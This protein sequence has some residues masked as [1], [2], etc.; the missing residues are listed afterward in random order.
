MNRHQRR[1]DLRCFR[2]QVHC[3]PIVTHLI[4]A[5]ADLNGFPMLAKIAEAW[6]ASI[7]QRKPWC[8][9]CEASFAEAATSGAFLF[10]EPPGAT[11]IAS[12]SVLC[13]T[14]W[15]DLPDDEIEATC[16]RVLS[17]LVPG[18]KFEARR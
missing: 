3:G 17:A 4:D 14:C 2:H 13:A 15:R 16:Q 1:A 9:A 11:D 5:S 7:A 18:G 10:A 12:I 6:R 8:F